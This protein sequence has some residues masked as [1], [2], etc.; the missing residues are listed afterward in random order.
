MTLTPPACFVPCPSSKRASACRRCLPEMCWWCA[1][2]I[3]L[4][5]STCHIFV[6]NPGT[7]LSNSLKRGPTWS[8]PFARPERLRADRRIKRLCRRQEPHSLLDTCGGAGGMGQR[9]SGQM[10]FLANGFRQ[11]DNGL[12]P[13]GGQ[14]QGTPAISG[15]THCLADRSREVRKGLF[16]GRPTGRVP[17]PPAHSAAAGGPGSGR[18]TSVPVL[19]SPV[20]RKTVR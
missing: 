5:W 17:L 19:P 20:D 1:P 11:T 18:R 13:D 8:G 14:T 9:A 7:V 16:P 15:N 12:L 4:P 2:M 6:Q 10:V 3:P